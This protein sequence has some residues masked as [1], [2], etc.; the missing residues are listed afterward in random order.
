M[1]T[2]HKFF[3]SAKNNNYSLN[4][5]LFFNSKFPNYNNLIRY[6]NYY[7]YFITNPMSSTP[8]AAAN[9]NPK[10]KEKKKGAEKFKSTAVTE[11]NAASTEGSKPSITISATPKGQLKDFNLA[12]A[13]AYHPLLVEAAWDTW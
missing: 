5:N 1:Q 10:A 2:V 6:S 4:N 7:K 11:N 13:D 8:A 9:N 3:L 12:M